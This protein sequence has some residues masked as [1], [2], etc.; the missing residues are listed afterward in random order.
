[1]PLEPTSLDLLWGVREIAKA[2]GRTE[3]Q[4]YEMCAEGQLPARQVGS[5]WVAERRQLV[6]FFTEP[7]RSDAR[8]S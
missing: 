7:T 4:T 8:S 6:R 2:I 1:M 5:R 3:R